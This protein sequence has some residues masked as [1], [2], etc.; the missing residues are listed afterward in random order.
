MNFNLVIMNYQTIFCRIWAIISLILSASLVYAQS[1]AD[2]SYYR[3]NIDSLDPIEGIWDIEDNLYVQSRSQNFT[4][5][6]TV[7][8]EIKRTYG[9]KFKVTGSNIVFERIGD[10]NGYTL[11]Y[12]SD[13]EERNKSLQIVLESNGFSFKYSTRESMSSNVFRADTYRFIKSYPTRSMYEDSFRRKYDK[14]KQELEA[15]RKAEEEKQP[16]QWTGTGFALNN[17]YIVTNHHVIE[18][19]Q[20]I[21]IQG[22][23][24]A[25][26][27]Y[28][29]KV[30]ASDRNNDLAILKIDDSTF[31]GFGTIP[32]RVSTRIVDVGEDVFVLG[33][34]LT[35]YMGEEIKLTNGII[36][37]RTG[38]QGDVSSYQISAPIQPGNSGAPL[39]DSKGDII[40]IINAGISQADNVGY[41]VKTPYLNTLLSTTLNE[42]ILPKTAVSIANLSLPEKVKKIR[43]FIF[44]IKCSTKTEPK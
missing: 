2:K 31:D 35:Q 33:Y 7:R 8:T 18:D 5:T 42:A 27:K 12:Y 3:D 39:F 17:G 28:K 20:D 23:K 32:Y 9:N 11:T 29:A 38:Y 15:A 43:N 16:K 24:G 19:A 34:P 37:S 10:T 13:I 22:V 25:T 4:D 36:S 21:S 6:K 41:A 44:F 30:I 1:E 14:E 26:T 40:G